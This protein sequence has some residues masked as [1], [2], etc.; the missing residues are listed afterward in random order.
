MLN[1]IVFFDLDGT[2]LNERSDVNREVVE[3]IEKL[4]ENGYL[5]IVATGRTVFE[6]KH[7][8]EKTGIQS[9]IS[10]NG[11]LGIL[12]GEKVFEKV[13]NRET[14]IRLREMVA[15]RKEE[16]AFYNAEQITI[17]GHNELVKNAY[18]VLNSPMPRIDETMYKNSH[19]NMALVIADNG[20][21]LYKQE[22]PELNFV[23]NC[24][25]SID[26]ISRGVS[27]A[28]GIKMM[29]QKL[30]AE[31]VPTFAFGDGFNDIE[32]IELVDYGIA[33]GNAVEPLKEKAKHIT[34]TNVNNGI[35]HGL[36]HF[37]LI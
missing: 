25:Y 27:K 31:N 24:D 26:V 11:Q 16:I 5:P 22:F 9:I 29:L 7:I 3:A 34:E 37:N 10:M 13:I 20:D 28:T 17:T 1:G 8:L 6:I 2:L 32:M 30:G 35:V 4:K 33:M 23:R 14:L 12:N 15:S 36:K 19:V 21:E 18:D